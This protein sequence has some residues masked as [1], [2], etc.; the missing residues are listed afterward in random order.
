M[1]AKV[2]HFSSQ[3]R[4]VAVELWKAKVPLKQIRDQLQ[5]SKVT[6]I[7]LLAHARNH[8]NQPVKLRKKGTGLQNHKVMEKTLRDMKM[9][10]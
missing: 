6:L 10:F 7:C 5:M 4:R 1:E 2:H 3:T 9:R 8:P